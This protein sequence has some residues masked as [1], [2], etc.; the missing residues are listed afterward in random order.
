MTLEETDTQSTEESSP[1][2]PTELPPPPFVPVGP[3]NVEDDTET[4]EERGDSTSGS[5]PASS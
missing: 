1:Q 3:A 5:E 2:T 4:A